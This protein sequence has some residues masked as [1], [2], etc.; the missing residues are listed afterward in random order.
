MV[1]FHA[2][3]IAQAV[4]AAE[5]RE[6]LADALQ[7]I[8]EE[9]QDMIAGLQSG[10]ADREQAESDREEYI[11]KRQYAGQVLTAEDVA[12]LAMRDARIAAAMGTHQRELD[13]A[14]A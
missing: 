5:V 13:H 9:L 8:C 1:R 2:L 3:A 4:P 6:R 10:D 12:F 14:P 11:L 7:G